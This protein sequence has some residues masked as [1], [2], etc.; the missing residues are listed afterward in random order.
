MDTKLRQEKWTDAETALRECLAIRAQ[1]QPD[2]WSTFNTRSMLGEA[3]LR[4]ARSAGKG[5]D[6]DGLARA[7]AMYRDAEPLLTAGY[8]GLRQYSPAHPHGPPARSLGAAGLPVRGDRIRRTA[9]VLRCLPRRERMSDIRSGRMMLSIDA[10]GARA[11]A[12]DLKTSGRRGPYREA[13]PAGRHGHGV[14]PVRR[15]SSRDDRL[16]KEAIR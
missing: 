12:G 13:S 10:P 2:A 15:G 14:R 4:Q 5:N 6:P 16:G 1:Q 7:V 8:T 3:L 9:A 11:P